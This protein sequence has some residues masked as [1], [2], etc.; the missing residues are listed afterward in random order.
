MAAGA[1]QPLLGIVHYPVPI[2]PSP[3]SSL[4]TWWVD[5]PGNMA[6]GGA[7]EPHV[8]ANQLRDVPRCVPGH[9]VVLLRPHRIGVAACSASKV[10]KSGLS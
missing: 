7:H 8:P 10:W 4:S 1:L 6:A 5:D 3:V 9:N 2:L